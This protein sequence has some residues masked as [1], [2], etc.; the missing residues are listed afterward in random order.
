MDLDTLLQPISSAHPCGDTDSYTEK[1]YGEELERELEALIKEDNGPSFDVGDLKNGSEVKKVDG[2]DSSNWGSLSHKA[3]G[4]MQKTK[5]LGLLYFITLGELAT[6]GGAVLHDCV[7]LYRSSLDRYWDHI[8]P[9]PDGDDLF[10]RASEIE[11]LSSYIVKDALCDAPLAEGRFGKISLNDYLKSKDSE[12]DN[13]LIS[14]V[15]DAINTS[16]LN[17]SN[18][19]SELLQV[20]DQAVVDL[21]TFIEKIIPLK[22]GDEEVQLTGFADAIQFYKTGLEKIIL[23]GAGATVSSESS[24]QPHQK[25]TK[26]VK[27]NKAPLQGEIQSREDVKKVIDKIIRFYSKNEPTS[28][29]PGLMKRAKKMVGMDFMEVIKEFGLDTNKFNANEIFGES[30]EE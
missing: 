27:E 30:D 10:D 22:F 11:Q 9:L 26:I 16:F 15:N 6:K 7:K 5:H 2:E 29:V 23:E 24:D 14:G 8:Y 25:E 28:P 12:A 4:Y 1:L 21:E 19:F 13:E 17:N 18:H 20:A 3:S